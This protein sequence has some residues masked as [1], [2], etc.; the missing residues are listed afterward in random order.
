[1][2]RM[3]NWLLYLWHRCFAPPSNAYVILFRLSDICDH[4]R[5]NIVGGLAEE[6]R[7]ETCRQ[8]Q[9]YSVARS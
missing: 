9:S 5:H 2:F 4:R 7:V 6:L 1:M 3:T 8:S